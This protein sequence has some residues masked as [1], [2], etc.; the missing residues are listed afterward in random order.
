MKLLPKN[1]PETHDKNPFDRPVLILCKRCGEQYMVPG[2]SEL[3]FCCNETPEILWLF[4]GGQQEAFLAGYIRAGGER[5]DSFTTLKES[6]GDH[7]AIN[8]P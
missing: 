1:P 6:F 2:E 3:P 7:D 8:P 4:I 5:R